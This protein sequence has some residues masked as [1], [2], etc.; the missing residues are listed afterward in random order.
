MTRH[1]PSWSTDT[2]PARLQMARII[3]ND[4]AT[5]KDGNTLSADEWYQWA[6][7]INTALTGLVNVLDRPKYSRHRFRVRLFYR[8]Q[9]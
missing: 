3:S 5:I 6:V 9:H 7:R 1:T 2:I 4:F 8:N